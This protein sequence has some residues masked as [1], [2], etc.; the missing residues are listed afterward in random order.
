[1]DEFSSD[2]LI[3][4]A[5]KEGV[6]VYL[7]DKNVRVLNLDGGVSLLYRPSMHNQKSQEDK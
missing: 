6:K 4:L 2:E 1:M 5:E 3:I 7:D